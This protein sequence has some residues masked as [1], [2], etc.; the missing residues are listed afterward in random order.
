MH[1]YNQDHR[2]SAIGFVTPAQRHSKT[3]EA[4][5]QARAVVYEQARQKHPTR[6]SQKTRDWRFVDVVNLNPDNPQTKEAENSK[7]VA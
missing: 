4:L 2:H 6:W 1:W 3:D 5:L 7:K